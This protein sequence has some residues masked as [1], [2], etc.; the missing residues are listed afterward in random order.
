MKTAINHKTLRNACLITMIL[1]GSF[2]NAQVLDAFTPRFNETVNGD[3]TM[4]ANNMLSRTATDN[5][6]GGSGN[7]SFNNNVY[8]DIDGL[9]DINNDN[10]DD[11][12][13][14]SSA[15]F[16]N[17]E[18]QL[19]CL[20]MYK[21]YLYWA[22]ADR[23]PTTDPTSENQPNWNYND[24]MLMLPGQTQYTT[25]T[26]DDV[27]YRGRNFHINN[28]P[29][30]C[31]KDITD[32]VT[33][34]VDPY[35]TYQVAN[36]EAK[37]GSVI[38]H[39]GG[40]IGT[41]GGWQIVFV[42]ESPKLPAKN[43]SL[44]DGYA[45]VTSAINNFDITF[46]GFQTVPTGDVNTNVIIGSLEGD[47]DLSGDQLQIRDTNNN[48]VSITA[49][50]RTSN[51]FFNSRITIG[52]SDF[53]DRN[54]ASQ[55]TLG[56]D[57]AV[58]NLDNTGNNII[59]NNQTSATL[60]LTS[61]QE[62]Y[63]LFLVGLCVDVWAPD[64]DPI[65]IIM[66][67]GSTPT[68]AGSSLGFNFNIVNKGNDSAVNLSISATLPPQIAAVNM[69]NTPTGVTYNFNPTTNL[70]EFFIED[71][72]TDVGDP[73]LNVDFDVV[74]QDECYFLEDD[75]DLNFDLQFTANY[76][77]IQNPN[78][79]N[80]L[81]SAALDNCNIGNKLPLIVEVNQP[82]VSWSNAPGELD[83]T[84]DCSDSIALENAQNLEPD[85]DKC[86]F[87]LTKTSGPFVPDPS[88]PTNGTYTNTWSFTDACNTTIDAYIQV[89][90]VVDNTPPT[91][92][93]PA[94]TTVE[95]TE[96]TDP[97]D[98]GSATATDN[99]GNTRVT[100]A[101]TSVPGCGNTE[102][103]TRTWTA[104]DDCGNTVSEDQIITVVDTTDPKL[105]IPSK[106]DIEC[107]ESTD[108]SNT[109][110]A[111]ATEACGNVTITYTDNTTVVC[112]NAVI[113]IRTWTATDDCGNFESDDQTITVV[114]TVNPTLVVPAD[115]TIE[116]AESTD[117]ADTG[118]ATA[119]DTCGNVTVTYADASV[120]GC[121]N[122]QIIT[123][124]WTATD[125]CDNSVSEDQII[126]VVDTTPPSLTIPADVT[127]ECTD[128][129]NPT[130]TGNATGSDNCG[131]VDIKYT[132]S[133]TD[134][135]GFTHIYTRTWTATDECGNSVSENQ[136][137]TVV[138]TT[139]PTLSV[140]ADTTIECTESADPAETGSATASDTCGNATVTYAD[141]SVPGC[142][143]TQTI[144]RT[145]TATDECGNSV[146]IDQI[147]TVVD[148]TPPTF[149]VPAD[150]TIEC[151]Q[152]PS[153]LTLTG[154]VTDEADNCSTGLEATFVDT[155]ADGACAN[156]SVITRTWSLTDD[157]D[158]TTTLVQTITVEDTTPP[159]FT[160][161]ADITIEC[162]QDPS[163]LTLTGDVT[164]EADNCS[165]GLEATFVD[166]VADGACA[167]ESVITRTWTLTDDCDNTTTLVQ[168]ITIEDTTPPTFTVPADI[169]IECDQDPSDL[170]LTG[171]V[172]DEADNCSTGLEATFV[173]TVADGACA[174]ESVITRTW[175][176]TDD[177]DNTT[178]LV[179][180]ITVEDTTPP[181]FTVPAD[182]TIECDQDPSDLT[183]TGDVTDEADNC[184]TGLEATFV[185]TVA[186][187]ACA[188]ESVITRTWSLTDDCDN[189]TTLVQTI[190]VEDTTPPTFTV[191][192]DITIECDQDPSD[193]TLTGDV[194]DEADNCSTGLEATFVDTVA[195]GAC[196]NESVITRTWS[197]TDDCD[198]TTTLVQTI[199]VEDTTPPTFT[200]PADI[201]IECDQDPSDL[202]L[203]GDVTDEAD[204]CSTG[205]E[206][207]F[208]D[209]VAD[210][211]CAN[212]SVI[213]RT[214][215]LTDDCDN[216]TTLVQT[217]TVEDTTPPT[218]TVPADITIECDQDPSDLT[219]TGDVTDEAD[220]CST[221]IEATFV[222]TVADGACA[223]ESVITRTWTLTDDCDNTTTLVQT[224]TIEDTTP[225]TFTVPADITIE[226][227]QDPSDLT[228]TGD[229]TDEV[230][231]CSTGLEATFVD[232]VADGA[233][234]N[235]SVITRTWSLTDDCDNT[236]TLV[237]T[238]TVEDTTPPD[239]SNCTLENTVLECSDTDNESLADA[240][241][242]ANIATLEACATDNCDTDLT[243]Q[244]TSDYDFNN[245]NTICGPCGNITVTYTV[246][247]D[248][249]NSS[250]ISATL[251]FDDGTTPDL[252]NC[253]LTDETIEC[254]GDNNEQLANIW[255]T[256]NITSLENCSDDISITVTSNYNFGNLVPS[257][258][259][260][261]SIAV[262]YTITDDCGN[263][264]TL[265]TT[266]I[267]EDTTP[268]TFT[269]PADVT[270]ECDQ[271]PS[272]LT[273]TGDVTD[274]ADNCSVSTLEATFVDTVA[275]GA[276]ANE[277]VITRTWSLTDD[278]DNTTTLVQTITVEDTTPPT[279]TVPADITIECDQDPS[280]LT[281]TGDVTDEA[282]NCSTGLE[283]T[284]VDTVADG[285][286][287]NESVITRTWSLTD[288]CDNTTTLVQTI[289]VEDT[290]PP[291]FTVPADITI[292]CDQDPSDLTL[293][294][295]VTDEAD[296]CSTGIEA[297]FVDT[298]ADGAC[299]N[300][301]VITRTWTLTDDCDNTTTLVQT[302]TIEDTTPPTFTVP[303]DITIECDQDPSD[304]TLTGDVTDEV[305]NCSTG[306]EAT[307]VDTVADGACANESV[308]TRT[309]SLTDDCDN[310]TT[311]VQTI[312]VEDTTPP[313]LSNCTL[314]NTVLECS[315][316]DNESL[317]DAWNAANIATLE[318]CATDNCDTD[319]TGQVTSDYDFNNLNTIC[320]P[321]GNITVTYT[322]TD[323]CGNSSTIS[324]TLTFDDGTTPDLSNCT[325]TD[326]TIECE[327]DNNE[328]LANIWNTA[329][330]TSLE[331]CSDDIS[332][333][334]T[335]NYN[336]G[337]LVPSCG[338]AGSIA[339]V[340]TITDD[341]GNFA[342]LSTTLIIEDTTPP[343]FTVPADVTIEC[344]QDPSDLT[345]TGDVTDEADN[346]SVSTLEAT[347]VDTVA[348]GACANES[349]ITRTW[350]LTD[351]C[352]NTTTL[353]QT[354]TVEDTTPPTF[355][356]PAD[357]TIECDQDPSDLTLTGDVTDE[358]DN[359]STGLEATFVD[360]VADGACANESVITR[361][362]SLT[363]DCDNTTT[364]VQTITIEDTTPP[365][366]TV[367]A[368]ITIEC[369]QDP[370]DLTLTG[371]VTDE[372]D[373]CSTGLEATF[374]DTVA[375]GA[376]ANE[377]V[378]T[379]TWSLTDDCDNTT[380]LVQ[381]IT[382]EDTT[383]PTFTVPAD[384]TIECDQDPSDL[385]LTGD[386]TD[387]ADNCSTGLEATFVDT[388]ADGAC[389]NE[390]VITRTWSLTD[391]CD[392]TTTLVQTI[393]VEDTTPPTFTVPAD[394]T[395]ECDQDPSDLT[396]TGD[397]TDEADNCSTGLEATF[398]DT[399]ADGACANESV[400][401]RTWSL[402][403]DCDNTTTL[404][405]TITVEDTTPPTFTVP[406]D[407]TIECDQDPSDL[408]LTGD[409]T[410]EA[411]NCST[412]LEATFV[413]TVADGA[414]ANESVITRTWSLTD[415]CDNTTTLVQTITVEDTTPPT[416]TVPA[417]ITIEC[418]QDPS[419]L[420]LT[421]DVT[422]EVDNC[423]TGL[424]A[425]FVDT[426]A[427]GACANESVI[428]RTWSLTDDCDNTTT[429]VQ[430]ITVEDTTP[431][432]FTV[433]AD[434][435]I[436]CD[437]DP[438][439][440]TLTGDVTDEADNCST[441]L[442][443]TF[444][445]TVA[446][447]AC[448]N[449][450]VIT[451]T[452]SLTDDCDNTTTLV[453]TITVEDTTPPTFTVPA[454]I[455]IECDQD[456]SDLTLTG[457]VT[458]EADNCSTGLEA[459]FVDTVADGACAN[460]SV[461]TR[462]WSLT[463]DC[464]NTTTL[465]QTITV[466]D[467]TPPTFTVPADITIECD[468]DP[469][470]LTLTGDVTDEADNCS[471]GLEATFVD[472]VTDGDCPGE[473]LITRVWTLTDDC[474]N[475][476]SFVQT[477]TIE[478]NTPPALVGDLEDV[479]NVVCSEIPEVPELVFEDACSS[480]ITVVFNETST[481]DGTATDYEIIRDWFVSD[482]CGNESVFTQTIIVSVESDIPTD[483]ATLCITEDF[484]FD[485][486]DLLLGDYD[487][488]G[489]WTVTS[490]DATINGSFFNPSSLL[491]TD[492]NFTE[493]QLGDYEF[494]Y[495]Y[496]GEC[497]GS[498][499]V[500][501]N[502][503]DDCVVLPCG[504]D[505]LIISKAVTVNFD[506]I[507]EFFTITGVEECGFVFEVQIFNRWG[508]KI[509][510]N[511]NYQNDW[512][513]TAS[514][515][516]IGRSDYV[517]TGT[518]YYVINIKNSGLKPITG[519]IYVSTK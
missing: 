197:L 124:T 31:F 238:I 473:A 99:C 95:C 350:S 177:C 396:L 192:A 219:L 347:F 509:Y 442:E 258:G 415:D 321:C 331:N 76:N 395:I 340:Y 341:C 242:A 17:P 183:L 277:S 205:L 434:V 355:T 323:D 202:T 475:A 390:S 214:W 161:P 35:G 316:T 393:T 246:T 492:D 478:D 71:G 394:I 37:L 116:C 185:D 305:D 107:T 135:C 129:I 7:H 115:V 41:S 113:I 296:N 489:I 419:D 440:L 389:A 150:I 409:V 240:W 254:E 352:D 112:G 40:N 450:S 22:A 146:S 431:P 267:I 432:T 16:S 188:N 359:C 79:Q 68:N 120:P 132:D 123:R 461:I 180:T 500:I 387:E 243:G 110:Q 504:E 275:D 284:F 337:N 63:G 498:V 307:F 155:V 336:F 301:S 311:L 225:P 21:A 228:L 452:W 519:P 252:S 517:P 89:I 145:W 422:D 29:Y 508:A 513:G 106:I 153:D 223:N 13:N 25:L 377:S 444:V 383:P 476:T 470:D 15:N 351:D 413:D 56:F 306:L 216:T 414:C 251:T 133:L 328:Q 73:A 143:N 292:E 224:I 380:T 460:E 345:L 30:I 141:T 271:D 12:F 405:Q 151:D 232:T 117:P 297:T 4:V 247:D 266:L 324:A 119:A 427:D 259:Q 282:D 237:Q 310:T 410:D 429:L 313:D 400:I 178:T 448:A 430:T 18:P 357:I 144:T 200:V 174:N 140:P 268:P 230:D 459:T 121:G 426:V 93:I 260:A 111:T 165:T 14:S 182:I 74:I 416:F 303:A 163:D 286:C 325:L 453:Q 85:T 408:T 3:V 236:T 499:T 34:L 322:V 392:N 283:A 494:T 516:S 227:D 234:A 19:T 6:N 319:L 366:F 397:V 233:C 488:D 491:D 125:D 458:D 249:G 356:V 20:S 369:D 179:Q 443:A 88:C 367:P 407:I 344:D 428:T 289:T 330:I 52:N 312:T 353:V 152:D 510:E 33:G 82:I 154:D 173:D 162:D 485:L 244:V 463:D 263:F 480:N 235:E 156:E 70:L 308:I 447:G 334:V 66:D 502:I 77:G 172:T 406:A 348:D 48:F 482:E 373:N 370:S 100:Y 484:D 465:V 229:V 128:P 194:T 274:E 456:P 212:E 2:V 441:G 45:N 423:S 338:Q 101:D 343:T 372:A 59:A 339:V 38:G 298:V 245:L 262:V 147:I 5:Y 294:G 472:T 142:G 511:F 139:E 130:A 84:V 293:T 471:T 105:T 65:E 342:T 86:D 495:T 404:V 62:T 60:R 417:D 191:P 467:T 272:D 358:A 332:I 514:N 349:V 203:T 320:G 515:A 371:D 226:C 449:E 168:T 304:L 309:W 49:P 221:G 215:S 317:A 273:L 518:Y 280:D 43:I 239:L 437:Q 47:R 451:R 87:T 61:N 83:T 26:A 327:G 190:T 90:T 118:S 281:L 97:A 171:D 388:V 279:F 512:N 468:Q 481:A 208:V 108:P 362:W 256:A 122:T 181:T 50:Q 365:T 381:T 175:S 104:T 379:R 385:T 253:T 477:I 196:A 269:V 412:G 94:D 399:V 103:I 80:S 241:N 420:T 189:T 184:S 44:F 42:Y 58:F 9:V 391:D 217:I 213:T 445:D 424:E 102:T 302:I 92:S 148:A 164:D 368:D 299:A 207:T 474:D 69:V 376:C 210:G 501:I 261:G 402:T 486:F 318:A 127:V 46:G 72:Y 287:A 27:I 109:G 496:G 375:D 186:D 131:V 278:C 433:P 220:N 462:T 57:A 255:N 75:C 53:L 326:E 378:I 446:D 28:D 54:P 206:A 222:D 360:T 159:T 425:T 248:C 479:I 78:N 134:E 438:S 81:S 487:V 39:G 160:V 199:T 439:D 201:T 505:D 363:D 98:T 158:N 264:A 346:C 364:L 335:S 497:P 8:V 204:N 411:D 138:D 23:E 91:I 11:T 421:G 32:Q 114:D 455:T 315:D 276:C 314:E 374:V 483:D 24:I 198:N 157:C 435:T 209:T 195:D 285:A 503:N 436:E 490:G 361:T 382:V 290:T 250:T 466:E 270:I 464:D 1:V 469:S 295:D 36:V 333:T 169:T 149:T 506:G 398:V 265:S 288:D 176:L 193:L 55:N 96:S 418:D 218:F 187:G 507:N 10:I 170:T 300:E 291:T 354:I 64:L 457:D 231:N 384:I 136:I 454:D 493:D 51:N 401:T 167:N 126:T 211:A 403:D 137:I 166:T 386:V 257:C 329:N 67:T